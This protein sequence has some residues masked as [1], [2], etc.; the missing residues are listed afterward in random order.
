MATWSRSWWPP[1]ISRAGGASRRSGEDQG[2]SQGSGSRRRLTK[3]EDAVDRAVFIPLIKDEPVLEGK[4]APRERA[5]ALAA[6]V[7]KGMRA[8]TIQTPNVASGVAGFILPG[9]KVDV[10]LTVRRIVQEPTRPA[11]AARPRCSRTSRSWPS[12]RRSTPRPRTR[13]T[14][15]SSAR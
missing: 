10:L 7:P 2:V 8:F 5:A 6:L 14:P 11:A 4:L 1:S 12:T 13:S 3:L 9:N 15:R